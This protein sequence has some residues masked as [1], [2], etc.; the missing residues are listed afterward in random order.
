MYK[1]R[2]VLC[3][4]PIPAKA[5]PAIGSLTPTNSVCFLVSLPEPAILALAP[6]RLVYCICMEIPLQCLLYHVCT[7]K[8]KHPHRVQA[9]PLTSHF[10]SSADSEPI[11]PRNPAHQKTLSSPPPHS[12]FVSRCA[13][14]PAGNHPHPHPPSHYWCSPCVASCGIPHVSMDYLIRAPP[15]MRSGYQFRLLGKKAP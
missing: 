10:S 15:L 4:T 2:N 14:S 7:T 11:E 13:D 12:S 9:F 5:R 3:I 6:Y 1:W 8:E